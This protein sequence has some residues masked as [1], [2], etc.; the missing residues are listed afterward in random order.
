M[1]ILPVMRKISLGHEAF[2]A[3]GAYSGTNSR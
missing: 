2:M 1:N 3:S